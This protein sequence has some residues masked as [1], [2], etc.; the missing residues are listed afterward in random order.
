MKTLLMILM[1][2]VVST[3]QA[4]TSNVQLL[5][6]L[7][8]E[9]ITAGE[10]FNVK[11]ESDADSVSIKVV[12]I[13]TKVSTVIAE[14]VAGASGTYTWEVPSELTGGEMYLLKIEAKNHGSYS[15]TKGFLSVTRSSY[16][17]RSAPKTKSNGL[18]ES[19]TFINTNVEAKAT[20][21]TTQQTMQTKKEESTL[22]SETEDD[23]FNNATMICEQTVCKIKTFRIGRL[24]PQ[25]VSG[26][27]F[28][29]DAESYEN[30]TNVKAELYSITGQKLATIWEGN[31]KK[32]ASTITMT[33]NDIP[34]GSY[35]FY[36]KNN[37][38]EVVD[39]NRLI[40]ADGQK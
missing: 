2:G 22:S 11:W 23:E 26:N 3:L 25:P 4:Q 29:I 32:G 28:T 16:E 6:P 13:A 21:V 36:L 33:L 24:Y 40:V 31:L 39:Y 10:N 19:N 15:W 7:G 38:D 35:I 14:G 30:A 8:G 20:P 27:T 1:L 18:T 9:S 37:K 5:Y 17:Q 34:S 12:N